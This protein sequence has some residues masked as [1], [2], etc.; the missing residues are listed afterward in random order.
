MQELMTV[1]FSSHT[2]L[3]QLGQLLQ[4]ALS[5]AHESNVPRRKT[6]RSPGRQPEAGAHE[7]DPAS[8]RQKTR[9]SEEDVSRREREK[10]G[11]GAE[12]EKKQEQETVQWSG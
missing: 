12:I 5:G 9:K 8:K 3:I 1:H 10:M 7:R 11:A 2:Q 6:E 4:F